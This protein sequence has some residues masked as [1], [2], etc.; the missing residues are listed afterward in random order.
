VAHE[1]GSSVDRSAAR[2]TSFSPGIMTAALTRSREFAAALKA[3]RIGAPEAQY[4]VGLMYANGL[5]TPQDFSQAIVWITKAAERGLPAAQYLLATR[6]AGGVAVPR[7]DRAAFTWYL[8][9]SEQGHVKATYKLGQMLGSSNEE[10]SMSCLLEAAQAGLQEAQHALG[11]AFASGKGQTQDAMQAA[12]WFAKA[13]G[14]GYAPAQYALACACMDGQGGARDPAE[15]LKWY[16]AAAAQDHPAAQV[17]LEL[18]D[19]ESLPL[20][21]GFG[22]RGRRRAN[23]KERRKGSARWLKAAAS[24]DPDATYHV[25]LMH[26][27]GLGVTQDPA[28]AKQLYRSAAEQSDLRAQLALAKMLEE[29]A[30]VVSAMHWYGQAASQGSPEAECALGRLYSSNS[31][32]AT[33]PL[34]GLA[35][36]ARAA[37]NKDPSALWSLGQ[38]LSG[39]VHKL[40]VACLAGAAD[41]GQA[42][43]QFQL[44]DCY[45]MGR[46]CS[47]NSPQAVRL[48]MLAAEQGH[49]QAAYALGL[50]FRQGDGI[51][52]DLGQAVTWFEKAAA[53]G[54]AKA[55]WNL[56]GIYISGGEG[57]PQDLK[58]AFQYCQQSAEQGFAP[59]QASLGLLYSR[60]GKTALAEHWL[61]KAAEQGDAEACFNLAMLL[62]SSTGST[63]STDETEL[64]LQCLME[65]AAQG[66]SEAQFKLGLM[67][68]T[69]DGVL[70]DPVEAHK[71]LLIAL[72]ARH[73]LARQNVDHSL[74]LISK[75]QAN[76]A[77]RRA[78]QWLA[79]PI[80]RNAKNG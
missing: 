78:K 10:A 65:A 60:M 42:E 39:D 34:T 67:F 70:A 26:E 53:A 11:H 79:L 75:P 6:Y 58:R 12:Q 55:Q 8:R 14:Q 9:A 23:A 77:D 1:L 61:R 51:Q 4:E 22:A 48:W 3:A 74:T 73:P 49:V 28:V 30:D 69:G 63:G 72:Q 41:A 46:G 44:G 35:W 19:Q 13:A 66:L 57:V 24:G 43:A 80:F 7:D 16:R 45:S 17:A 29:Q 25:A 33:D 59:G 71:W 47:R 54:H 56:G 2:F 36:Y 62:R 5:G 15:A 40:A 27:L 76:E 18:I 37:L 20:R 32:R 21:N 38:L 31:S 52:A 50:A 64:I 68:A